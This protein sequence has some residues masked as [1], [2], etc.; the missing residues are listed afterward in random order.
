MEFFLLTRKAGWYDAQQIYVTAFPTWAEMACY[1]DEI[2]GE[3]E[4]WI[5]GVSDHLIHLKSNHLTP[6][7]FLKSHTPKSF[8]Q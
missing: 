1:F 6:L 2:S 3:T 4:V 5:A 7:T 8:S